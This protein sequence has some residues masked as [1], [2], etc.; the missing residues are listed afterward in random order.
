MIS[1]KNK[2]YA[3]FKGTFDGVKCKT[4][5]LPYLFSKKL[6]YL[7]SKNF[8]FAFLQKKPNEARSGNDFICGFLKI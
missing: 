3:K 6:R 2:L 8:I 1:P 5:P 7:F 4:K